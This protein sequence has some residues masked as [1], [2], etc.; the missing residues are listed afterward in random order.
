[1]SID[2]RRALTNKWALGAIGLVVFTGSVGALRYRQRGPGAEYCDYGLHAARSGAV[3]GTPRGVSSTIP[4]AQIAWTPK[5]DG[6][7]PVG[8]APDGMIW[9][10]GGEFW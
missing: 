4:A 8:A 9:I 6:R 10:P 3:V 5:I 7:I 1:M 2:P